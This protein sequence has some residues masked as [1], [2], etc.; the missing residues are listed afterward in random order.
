MLPELV[1]DFEAEAERELAESVAAV[2]T[3]GIEVERL[4]VEGPAGRSLLEASEG[5][6]MLV[7]G[8]RGRG[9]FKGLLLG[10]VSGQCAH[11]AEC[12]VVIVREAREG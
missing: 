8:S 3:S 5:A 11:H 4:T 10:S 6:A 12:P 2:D 9:G 7:V 1:V